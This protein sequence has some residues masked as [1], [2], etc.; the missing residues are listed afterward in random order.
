MNLGKHISFYYYG[1]D[2]MVINLYKYIKNSMEN[3]NF[4]FLDIED[5]V[6][7]LLFDSLNETEKYMV[8]KI[9]IEN[10]IISN[11][12]NNSEFIRKCMSNYKLQKTE[13]GFTNVRFI[14]DAKKII[15]N[16]SK[17]LFKTFANYCFNVIEE[18]K[19]DILTMYDFGEYMTKGKY[20]SDEIIKVSYA[21]HSHRMFANEILSTRE[22]EEE[23]HLA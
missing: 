23:K 8:G 13:Q 14:F 10:I 2:H 5:S 12:K 16:T 20:I 9:N 17:E 19:I 1:E 7:N 6:Y 3:N 21:E 4:I 11:N 15:E 18:E 22:F